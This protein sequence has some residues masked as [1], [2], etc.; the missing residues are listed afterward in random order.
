M[1]VHEFAMQNGVSYG[2]DDFFE[3][4]DPFMAQYDRAL[5]WANE[6]QDAMGISLSVAATCSAPVGTGSII[7]ETTSAWEPVPAAAYKRGVRHSGPDG[8]R[9]V[10]QY[11]VDPT[12]KR[13]IANGVDPD[14]IEDAYTL[15]LDVER[16]LKV[17]AYAQEHIDQ[18]ISMTINLP[19]QMFDARE[20]HDIG[21]TLIK[22]LPK[23]RGITMY[24]DG[25]R[26]GQPITPV[27]VSFA[28]EQQGVVFE[29][30]EDKCASGVCGI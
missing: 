12:V 13:Q 7:A 10:H 21:D 15:A 19:H 2:G 8:D 23:L 26:A 18:G 20:Q 30:E 9:I 29:E 27:D 5:E 1:G 6:Q 4:L 22:Y 14:S 25:A 17:Q 3:L 16:R 11:V 28:L 24:P